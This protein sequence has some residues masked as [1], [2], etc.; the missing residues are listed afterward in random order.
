MSFLSCLL[1]AYMLFFY[2][3]NIFLV[4]YGGYGG[5]GGLFSGFYYDPKKFLDFFDQK[6]EIFTT[7]PGPEYKNNP[8]P[9]MPPYPPFLV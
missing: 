1:R 8:P 4:G 2:F 3:I 6:S 7:V 5:Y 9:S